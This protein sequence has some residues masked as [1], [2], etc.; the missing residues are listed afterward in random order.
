M[1]HGGVWGDGQMVTDVEDYHVDEV[2]GGLPEI[3]DPGRSCVLL[4]S[5][6]HS[7]R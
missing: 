2:D 6:W 3:E 5:R 4:S 7:A 1:A